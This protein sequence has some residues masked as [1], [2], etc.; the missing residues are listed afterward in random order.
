MEMAKKNI[1]ITRKLDPDSII[2]DISAH[3]EP[4]NAGIPTVGVVVML[5]NG[6]K[7]YRRHAARHLGRNG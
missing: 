1:R 2:V 7:F 5:D 4:T 3:E 6:M